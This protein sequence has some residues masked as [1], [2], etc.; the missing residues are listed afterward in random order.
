MSKF[1]EAK[2][3]FLEKH[4]ILGERDGE[5]VIELITADVDKI[6]GEVGEARKVDSARRV[7]KAISVESAQYVENAEYV[8]NAEYV[9][10]A[11]NVGSAGWVGNEESES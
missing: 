3:A 2:Q 1:N 5:I 8:K 9:R 4:I 11:N 10:G 7:K 6:N